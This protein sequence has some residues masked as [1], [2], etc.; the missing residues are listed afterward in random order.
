MK[1][2]NNVPHI[3]NEDPP[4]AFVDVASR[5]KQGVSIPVIVSGKIFS[6]ELG[7]SILEQGKSDMVAFGR[8]QMSL[9]PDRGS[10]DLRIPARLAGRIGVLV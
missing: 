10:R 3:T 6:P 4:G 1:L 7:E 9:E 2:V 8:Y 5:I